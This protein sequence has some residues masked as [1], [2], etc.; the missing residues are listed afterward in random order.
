MFP[1][2]QAAEFDSVSHK[3]MV[4]VLESS[5]HDKGCRIEGKSLRS[6]VFQG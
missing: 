1:P 5:M 2:Q 6:G 4:A 3:N